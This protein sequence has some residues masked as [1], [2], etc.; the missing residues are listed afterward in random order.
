MLSVFNS[1]PENMREIDLCN[2]EDIQALF[3]YC[4][5]SLESR[6]A[7]EG[8]STFI[9]YHEDLRIIWIKKE[10]NLGYAFGLK[11]DVVKVYK[12]GSEDE[13]SKFKRGF[14]STFRGDNS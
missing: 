14:A 10:L 11:N 5:E 3:A 12:I 13:W 9:D 4:W 1:Y 7:W 8:E 2:R 6:Q